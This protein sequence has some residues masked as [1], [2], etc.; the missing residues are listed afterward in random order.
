MGNDAT[1]IVSEEKDWNDDLKKFKGVTSK[2]I[3]QRRKE[4]MSKSKE[5]ICKKEYSKNIKRDSI[6]VER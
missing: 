4:A 3:A 6:V 5:N 2:S 1:R